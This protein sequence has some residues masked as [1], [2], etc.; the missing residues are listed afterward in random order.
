MLTL[1][2]H[3]NTPSFLFTR[4]G[5]HFLGETILV[6]N[7]HGS[8]SVAF[9]K[10]GNRRAFSAPRTTNVPQPRTTKGE[11]LGEKKEPEGAQTRLLFY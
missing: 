7:R 5:S 3:F 2:R 8:L 1:S 6:V 9:K 10:R 4:E 11:S